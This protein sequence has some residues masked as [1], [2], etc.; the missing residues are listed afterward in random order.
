MNKKSIK[1]I[2]LKQKKVI[3]RADFNVPL[4]NGII[5]DNARILATLPTINY[6]LEQ[7]SSLILMSHLGRPKGEIKP[8]LSLKPVADEL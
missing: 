1:D 6:I 4:Q 5:Q 2:N 8:E 7:N 3:M